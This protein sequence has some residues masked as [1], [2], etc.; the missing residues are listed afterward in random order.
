LDNAVVFKDGVI[1]NPQGARY[2]NEMVRH[3][4]LDALGDLFLAG[5]HIQGRLVS[6]NGGHGL[7]NQILRKLFQDAKA[8]TLYTPT[9]ALSSA[10]AFARPR[11]RVA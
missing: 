10:M 1:L 2:E 6:H 5:A 9:T 7:N 8:Y 3:K 4:V 11:A